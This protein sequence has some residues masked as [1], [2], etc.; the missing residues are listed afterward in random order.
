MNQEPF[1]RGRRP[2]KE[3]MANLRAV[4]AQWQFRKKESEAAFLARRRD[5]ER[6]TPLWQLMGAEEH[7]RDLIHDQEA[8]I[9][10][11]KKEIDILVNMVVQAETELEGVQA[12]I[13]RGR[14]E[15][16]AIQAELITSKAEL[17][18]IRDEEA[19]VRAAQREGGRAGGLNKLAQERAR[20]QAILHDLLVK[21]PRASNRNLV[22]IAR[23]RNPDLGLADVTLRKHAASLRKS[24]VD[25]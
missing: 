6:T 25:R 7:F 21:H 11:R 14:T 18:R 12:E 20:A 16:E 13:A 10:G 17:A 22:R 1:I 4:E 9:A 15:L 2:T 23:E 8:E 24:L 3:E 19:R 5:E